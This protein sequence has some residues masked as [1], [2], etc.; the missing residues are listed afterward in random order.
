MNDKINPAH[1]KKNPSGI[2][3]IEVTEHMNF[4]K[5]NAIKYVWR[6]GEK[7]DEIEDLKKA[8]WYIN[9]EME[10]IIKMRKNLYA[11]RKYISEVT[12]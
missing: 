10:R 11:N 2:E 7:G 6:S 5:G 1:Y 12:A 8:V 9:R 4:N 3:C